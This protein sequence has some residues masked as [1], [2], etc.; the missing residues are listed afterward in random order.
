MKKEI[1]LFRGV[2]AERARRALTPK[3]VMIDEARAFY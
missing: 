2:P 3:N 1:T